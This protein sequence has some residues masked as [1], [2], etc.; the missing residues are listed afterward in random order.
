MK[1]SKIKIKPNGWDL[2][3]AAAVILLAAV[4]VLYFGSG[5]AEKLTAVVSVDGREVERIAA[6][7]SAERTYTAGGCTLTVVFCP[8]GTPGVRMVSSDCPTQDCVHTGRISRAGQ[9][10][11]CLPA[12]F[13]VE[14]TG[15]NSIRVDAV[16]G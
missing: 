4:L 6:D 8:D 13:A 2:L 9:S 14:L 15:G 3:P 11:I 16:V 1:L 5:S 10:I 7:V 12:A